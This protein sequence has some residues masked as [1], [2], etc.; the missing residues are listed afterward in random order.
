MYTLREVLIGRCF[1]RFGEDS[2]AMN[3]MGQS[4]FTHTSANSPDFGDMLFR[5]ARRY[6]SVGTSSFLLHSCTNSVS[7]SFDGG[8]PKNAKITFASSASSLS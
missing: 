4:S 8:I 1:F 6:H 5:L 7:S 2:F 3:G